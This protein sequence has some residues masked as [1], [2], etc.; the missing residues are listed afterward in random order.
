MNAFRLINLT[1]GRAAHSILSKTTDAVL[2]L[3]PRLERRR[4]ILAAAYSNSA[5]GS[6]SESP[7]FHDHSDEEPKR[8]R[9]SK[10]M[11]ELNLCSRR[12]ADRLIQDSKVLLRGTPVE[13]VLGQK[14][15]ADESGIQIITKHGNITAAKDIGIG[16]GTGTGKGGTTNLT[17]QKLS[18]LNKGET[19]LLHKPKNFVSGQPDPRHGHTPAVRL[20]TRDNMF[21]TSPELKAILSDGNY[22]HF[23][24][25][26]SHQDRVGGGT[27]T[28][29]GGIGNGIGNGNGNNEHTHQGKY[30][31]VPATLMNYAPAGRLDL[32]SSG[33]LLFTQNGIVAKHLLRENTN[34]NTNNNSHVPVHKEYLVKVEPVVSLSREEVRMGMKRHH[35][36]LVPVWDLSIL[37]QGGRRLWD[38]RKALK[39]LIEVEWVEEGSTNTRLTLNDGHQRDR[40]GDSR[41]PLQRGTRSSIKTNESS[42]RSRWD[43]TGVIRMVLQEG[44]KRQIRRMCREILGLH[45][46]ELKRIRIGDIK[47]DDL[48]VGKWRPL[49]DEE[50][51]SLVPID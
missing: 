22:L 24:K 33:L 2:V 34:T 5:N 42:S 45:V 8:V 23:H 9:L 47:L 51:L 20:L 13:P 40:R 35:F 29:T 43:G 6:D 32:D 1:H 26:F 46:V 19:I 28:S 14:V 4:R 30:M 10:R 16:T 36:P 11:S 39:P 7:R 37:L 18:E 27:R 44:K 21:C 48:P 50:R 12:Q 49:T 31:D 15:D 3:R 41:R 25:R 38:D 17:I